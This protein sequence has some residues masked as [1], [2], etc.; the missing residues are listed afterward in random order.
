VSM[1][2][3]SGCSARDESVVAVAVRGQSR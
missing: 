2:E 1:S 3:L